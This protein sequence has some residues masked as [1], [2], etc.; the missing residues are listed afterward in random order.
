MSKCQ[1]F[2]NLPEIINVIMKASDPLDTEPGVGW[3]NISCTVTD[4]VAVDEVELV[5]IGDTT[6]EYHMIKDGDDYYCNITISTADEYTYH[7]WADD[8]IGNEDTS[9]LNHP[10]Y[11]QTGMLMRVVRFISWIL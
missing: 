9:T 8:L 2:N 3:E 6:T 4:N 10:I 7:I 1:Q 11:L 5:L